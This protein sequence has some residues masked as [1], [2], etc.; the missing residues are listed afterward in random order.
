MSRFSALANRNS[1]SIESPGLI[2]FSGKRLV[3]PVVGSGGW[4]VAM[5]AHVDLEFAACATPLPIRNAVPCAEKPGPPAQVE[6]ANQHSPG[7]RPVADGV[8]GARPKPAAKLR[9]PRAGQVHR[10]S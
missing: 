3:H 7:M 9:S 10:H 1:S 4:L 2:V 6:I 5:F 8:A